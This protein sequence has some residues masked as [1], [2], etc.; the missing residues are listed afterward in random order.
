MR[1]S[2]TESCSLGTLLDLASYS[3]EHLRTP[4]LSKNE[5]TRTSILLEQSL[6]L[7]STQAGLWIY[8]KKGS[9]ATSSG[10]QTSSK[11]GEKSGAHSTRSEIDGALSRDILSAITTANNALMFVEGGSRGGNGRRDGFGNGKGES[12]DAEVEGGNSF[13]LLLEQFVKEKVIRS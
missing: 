1:T 12:S 5:I 6:G 3:T 11:E 13:L 9:N 10:N 4:G 8:A 7:A 2:P